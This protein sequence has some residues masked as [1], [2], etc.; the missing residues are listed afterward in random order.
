MSEQPYAIQKFRGGHAIVYFAGGKRHRYTLG[1]SD[2]REA[3]RVAPALYA[4]LTRPKGN[5]VAE[6]W[7]GYIGDKQGRAVLATMTHTWKALAPQFGP[8][9]GDRVTIADCRAH[10]EARRK[11][12]I[13]DGTIHTELGHLR[14]VL[15]WA[16]KHGLLKEAPDIERPSKP[17]PRE[18]HLTRDQARAV[19]EAANMPHLRLFIILALGTGARSAAL[20]GLTWDRCDFIR[21]LIDLR[22]PA[23]TMPHKGRAIVPMNRTVRAALVE[24]RAG[25]RSDFVV[26]WAGKRVGSVKRGLIE[27]GKRA[28]VGKV[29]PHLFRHS[30]AV[31]MV[32]AG[33]SF[34]EVAQFLG[35]DDVNVTRKVY[36]RFSPNHLRTAAAALEYDDLGSMNLKRTTQ[37]GAK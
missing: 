33:I 12:G 2:A 11:A 35:H 20:L 22:D 1:T 37:G 7:Q 31:H 23:M 3:E 26:E 10:T 5:T 13:K 9:P 8:L 14:M 32:E 19:I 6:L 17:K 34:E 36:G 15:V 29:T 25:G 16:R 27:T 21:G 30:A 24:A 18:H 28:G 4:E